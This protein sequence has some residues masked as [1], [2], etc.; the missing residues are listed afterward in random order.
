[1]FTY[2]FYVFES[3]I[4]SLKYFSVVAK[5]L[6]LNKFDVKKN[7]PQQATI[8][9]MSIIQVKYIKLCQFWI[10]LILLNLQCNIA[11]ILIME[12]FFI[13]LLL[14]K[15]RINRFFALKTMLK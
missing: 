8:F 3:H 2:K 4:G 7:H 12:V 1:M 13:P 15:H 6:I 14:K 5:N 9:S 11:L 10:N